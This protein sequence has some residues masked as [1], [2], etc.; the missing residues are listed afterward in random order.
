MANPLLER[1][2]S[3]LAALGMSEAEA[4]QAAGIGRDTIRD[5][6][7]GRRQTL[8]GQTLKKLA[9][10]LRTTE[11]WLLS[12]DAGI[13]P[14]ETPLSARSE[15]RLAPIRGEAHP[16]P[17]ALP[18][19]QEMP[20]DVPVYGTAAGSLAGAFQFEGGVIDYVRRPP[21][22][23][24]ASGVYALYVTGDSMSPE[25]RSGDLRFV[26]PG[27]PPRSGDT[28]II[29]AKYREDG[30]VEAFIKHFIRRNSE[31][32]YTRQINPPAELEFE[33]RFVVHLHRVLTMNELF[34]V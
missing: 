33:T 19:R 30:P 24:G 5:L 9:P 7:R 8:T 34:G 23:I 16:A 17:V 31:K 6:R 1:I 18:H 14:A 13:S 2:E 4:C 28:V 10:V 20:K 32:I 29:Q 25:H 21:A 27:R 3:R 15:A 11:S 26:H 12:E 22:L